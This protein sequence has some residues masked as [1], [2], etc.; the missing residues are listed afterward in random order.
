MKDFGLKTEIQYGP[1]LVQGREHPVVRFRRKLADGSSEYMHLIC[2][3]MDHE[4]TKDDPEDVRV[5]LALMHIH[6]SL[7]GAL[8]HRAV[9]P[10]M[11]GMD[12]KHLLQKGVEDAPP[13]EDAPETPALHG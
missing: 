9:V 6:Q 4:Q 13:G 2:V 1:M 11:L 12:Y 10:F 3:P 7:L 8:N 5:N